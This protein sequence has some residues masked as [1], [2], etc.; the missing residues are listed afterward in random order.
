MHA[1]T[2]ISKNSPSFNLDRPATIS[3]GAKSTNDPIANDIFLRTAAV[4][5][6]TT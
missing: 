6:T 1:L 5:V 4:V 2:N 3:Y